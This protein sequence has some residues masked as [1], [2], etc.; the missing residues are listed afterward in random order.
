MNNTHPLLT[1]CLD[2]CQALENRGRQFNFN[3]TLETGFTFSL[4]TRGEHNQPKIHK[5]KK[6][7]SPST[8]KRD[9]RR[10]E[11]FQRKKGSD[12]PKEAPEVETVLQAKSFACDQCEKVYVTEKGLKTHTGKKHKTEVLRS[13]SPAPSLQVSPLKDTMRE[14]QSDEPEKSETFGNQLMDSLIPC[15]SC[16]AY[17]ENEA[18]MKDH[19]KWCRDTW[20]PGRPRPGTGPAD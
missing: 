7:K 8:L 10:K 6:R 4:D 16:V 15:D 14:E 12:T 18:D 19:L 13:S 1:Q 20:I 17:F 9:L 3:L 11:E 5:E 2:F